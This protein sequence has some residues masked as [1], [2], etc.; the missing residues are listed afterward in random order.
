MLIPHSAGMFLHE[1]EPSLSHHQVHVAIVFGSDGRLGDSSMTCISPVELENT[2]VDGNA[3]APRRPT[4]TRPTKDK[5]RAMLI[6][7]S[8]N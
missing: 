3:A 2:G 7:G 4:A 8:I 5:N 1:I 6:V